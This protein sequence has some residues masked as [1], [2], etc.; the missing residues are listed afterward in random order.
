MRT[1]RLIV[2]LVGAPVLV[3][4]PGAA[5]ATVENVPLVVA[6]GLR[7]PDDVA[8]APGEPRRLYIVEQ[9]GTIRVAVRGRVL[10]RPFLDIRP[11]VKKSLLQGLF[12]V[13]FHPSY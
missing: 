2:A 6:S 1:L 10:R 7:Q 12:A 4:L 3:L 9:R 11:L 8:V 13:A 5:Q